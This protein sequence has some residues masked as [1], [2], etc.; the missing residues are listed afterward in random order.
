MQPVIDAAKFNPL[1]ESNRQPTALSRAL[2][3]ALFSLR[4]AVPYDLA[5]VYQLDT[6]GLELQIASGPLADSR[7]SGH[8]IELGTHPTLGQILEQ[9]RPGLLDDHRLDQGQPDPFDGILGR[10]PEHSC[11]VAPLVVDDETLGLFTLARTT[12]GRF[13]LET[14]RLAHGY[15]HALAVAMSFAGRTAADGADADHQGPL[16]DFDTMQRNYFHRVLRHTAGRVYGQ[17]G[18]AAIVGMPPTTLQSRLKKL[19]IDANEH[20]R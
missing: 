4:E 10:T 19:G 8:R 14:V 1:T 17:R 6:R 7:L 16:V 9:R 3:A 20:R 12:G 15:G 5:A 2:E 18:A 11:L 13:P